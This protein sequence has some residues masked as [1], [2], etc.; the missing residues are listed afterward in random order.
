MRFFKKLVSTL[1]RAVVTLTAPLVVASACS[2]PDTVAT[3]TSQSG[4]TSSSSYYPAGTTGMTPWT[5]PPTTPSSTPFGTSGQ[6]N[7]GPG[8][9][10]ASTTTV[11]RPG[12]FS[13]V[14]RP[15]SQNT[16]GPVITTTVPP[17]VTTPTTVALFTPF[18]CTVRIDGTAIQAPSGSRVLNIVVRVTTKKISDAWLWVRAGDVSRK[19]LVKLDAAG[20]ASQYVT[21]PKGIRT[22]TEVYASGEFLPTSL[23]CK[24]SE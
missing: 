7:P 12:S 23:A 1:L 14:P 2:T 20:N 10:Q 16:A 15:G 13:T 17:V 4:A 5:G 22:V 18:D 3:A 19:S 11:F 21:V 8:G 6:G 9:T 24:D